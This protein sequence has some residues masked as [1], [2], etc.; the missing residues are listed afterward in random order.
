MSD[1]FLNP[2]FFHKYPCLLLKSELD[3]IE[4]SHQLFIFKIQNIFFAWTETNLSCCSFNCHR[5]MQELIRM[6]WTNWALAGGWDTTLH[7]IR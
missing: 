2:P 1:F 5:K 6:Y 7:S 3:N 4:P